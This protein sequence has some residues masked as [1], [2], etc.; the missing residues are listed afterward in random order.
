MGPRSSELHNRAHWRPAV[1][2]RYSA[3]DP[4]RATDAEAVAQA[5]ADSR[6]SRVRRLMATGGKPLAEGAAVMAELD[7]R[8]PVD[9]LVDAAGDRDLLIVG[10]RGLHGLGA[11]GSV[12][13]RVAH[14]APCR[15]L[16]PRMR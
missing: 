1:A 9:A 12:A 13:E 4:N 11:L 8:A 16:S 3:D 10:S 15:C 5:L 6:G 7:A 14:R 2:D